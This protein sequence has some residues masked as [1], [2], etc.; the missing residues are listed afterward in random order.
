MDNHLKAIYCLQRLHLLINEGQTG[1]PLELAQKLQISRR[2]LY[3]M[4]NLL[5][6]SGADIKYSRSLQ[7]FFYTKPFKLLKIFNE[8]FDKT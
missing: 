5:K 3:N 1:T 8:V 2:H 6:D 4:I 7:T